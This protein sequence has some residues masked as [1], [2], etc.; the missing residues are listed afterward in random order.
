M[1]CDDG[2]FEGLVDLF[3][4][5]GAL[6]Y[7]DSEARGRAALPRFTRARRAFPSERGKHVTTNFVI[8]LEGDGATARSD[9]VFFRF[10]DGVF[11]PAIGGRYRDASCATTGSGASLAREIRRMSPP[12][13]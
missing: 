12:A 4:A 2:D 5:D 13:S 7:G 6:V 9:F 8:D 11:T 1:R 3:T 10:V